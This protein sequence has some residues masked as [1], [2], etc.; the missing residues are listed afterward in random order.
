MARYKE[1]SRGAFFNHV[2]PQLPSLWAYYETLPLWCREVGVRRKFTLSSGLANSSPYIP[3]SES[4][5]TDPDAEKEIIL[6]VSCAP[7]IRSALMALE[8][9]SL[10]QHNCA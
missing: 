4:G 7:V 3:G 6:P 9:R 5:P 10:I 8:V 2:E 1:K